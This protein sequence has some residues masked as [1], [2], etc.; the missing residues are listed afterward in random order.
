MDQITPIKAVAKA[1]A[2]R[3][4]KMTEQQIEE[5]LEEIINAAMADAYREL[6]DDPDSGL[7]LDLAKRFYV[8]ADMVSMFGELLSFD[9]DPMN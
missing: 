1:L 8:I 2:K 3:T 9:G 4:E 5:T 6:Q 7:A